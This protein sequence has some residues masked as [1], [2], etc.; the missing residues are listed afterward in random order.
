MHNQGEVKKILDYGLITRSIIES[1]VSMKKCQMY[2][3]MA[4]SKEV[5]AFFQHQA[6]ELEGVVDYFKSKL[7]DVI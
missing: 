1:E 4:Q 2:S 5:K 7:S 3:Q 6:S